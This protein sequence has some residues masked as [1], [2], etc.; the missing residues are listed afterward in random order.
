MN[1][2]CAG[3]IITYQR[4]ETLL[5]T[6][7]K[8][9][10]QT[11]PPERLW[12]IDNS[13]DDK[14]R[15]LVW[16]LGDSRIEYYKVGYNGGPALAA[17]IGLNLAT[18]AGY[19]WIYWGDD[20]DPPF[21][22]DCFERLLGLCK[23]KGIGVLGAVGHNFDER[24]GTI[25]RINTDILIKQKHIEVDYVAGSMCM[26]VNKDVVVKSGVF[27]NP[28]LFFGF[29]ELDFC[30][31]VKEK[32]YKIVVDCGLFLEARKKANRL[33]FKPPI[34]QKKKNLTRE[35]YSLRNL[36]MIADDFKFT[37]MK[38]RLCW[39]WVAK[40]LYGFKYGVGYGKRNFYLITL[41]FIHY[42]KGIRGKTIDL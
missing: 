2:I 33:D 19:E 4:P 41:A 10:S 13:E 36:L 14:T 21:R 16:G 38:I 5:T 9:F 23:I 31:K 17:E 28:D 1:N 34:Y 18:K 8:V 35:Y 29:E 20:N 42:W 22:H 32:G 3:F 40:S 39:K 6:I 30:L 12:I 15:Q 26:L 7:D 24:A 11:F 25:K 37:N 27:P